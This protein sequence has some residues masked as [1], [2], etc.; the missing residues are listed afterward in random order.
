MKTFDG[1]ENLKKFALEKLNLTEE[2]AEKFSKIRLNRS[3]ATLS[4]SAI[5]KILPFLQK[6]FLYSQA[7]YLANLYKVL[8]KEK[9][10]NELTNQLAEGIR[11]IIENNKEEKIL[12]NIVNALI[13][14][15][16]NDEYPYQIENGRELDSA[17][18][19][20]ISTKVQDNFGQKT[21]DEFTYDKKSTY[22]NYV[23]TQ[24]KIFLMTQVLSRKGV[25]IK[26]PRLHDQIFKYLQ[27]QY[28]ISEEQKKYLWHP[29]EQ[30]NY[31]PATEYKYYTAGGKNL[32]I[33]E[34]SEQ[35]FLRSYANA[36]YQGYSIK[37]LGNPEPESKGFKNPMALKT[38]HKLKQLLNYLLQTGKIDEDTRIVIE[39]ARELN[40]ANRRKAIARWNNDRKV[41]NEGFKNIIREIN[42]ECKGA[43]FDENDKILI[44]KI[45]LWEE[46][47]HSCI[48]TGKSISFCDVFNGNNFDFEHTIPA[49]ISFDSE[50]KN[51]TLA[52]TEYNR[53]MKGKRFPTQMLNYYESQII[54]GRE[55]PAI[56]RSIEVLFG[57][58]TIEKEIIKG[59][60]TEIIHWAKIDDLKRQYDDWR[61]KATSAPT[62][63]YKDFC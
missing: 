40:D 29:S 45:R 16:L 50:L 58:R 25:F 13:Q 52:D 31:K 7:V 62:K 46:Q 44:R 41:E 21:W 38:L 8:G 27:N 51:L 4:L 39:I 2:K 10:S 42:R 32:Y 11:E 18:L 15:E 56:I 6:G 53:K 34:K 17:E 37:L 55:Y 5:K 49:S 1:Q 33:D 22:L 61:N 28:N 48:Y 36:E 30:E 12:N 60:E 43:N 9:I 24:F 59:K 20:K 47:K 23:S 26:Q 63:D 57:R 35:K 54:N 14:A 3:Y 19:L